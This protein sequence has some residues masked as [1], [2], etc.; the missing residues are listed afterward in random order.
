MSTRTLAVQASA[1][2]AELGSIAPVFGG[3]ERRIEI[4]ASKDGFPL[5]ASLF[6]PRKFDNGIGV[7]ISSAYATPRRPWGLPL[8]RMTIA[9]LAA[10]NYTAG[11]VSPPSCDIGVSVIWR[12]SLTGWVGITLS[13]G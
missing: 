2:A 11:K 6:Q 1:V 5:A 8:L 3:P 13:C 4:H 7:I 9:G 12:G 10:V